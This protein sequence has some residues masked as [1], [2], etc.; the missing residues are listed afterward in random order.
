VAL[1]SPAGSGGIAVSLASSYP[2]GVNV[3]ASVTIAP[4]SLQ[5]TVAFTAGTVALNTSFTITASYLGVNK[6][7]G[8]TL[9][10]V[11]AAVAQVN[12][13]ALDT[14]TQ[15][16]WKGKYGTE[17]YSLMGDATQN[18]TYVVPSNNGRQYTWATSTS[19]V[20]ALQKAIGTDRIAAAWYGQ[21]SFTIDL[22]FTDQMPHQVAIYCLDWDSFGPRAQRIEILDANNNVLD[23]RSLSSFAGAST[24]FGMSPAAS[25]SELPR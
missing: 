9:I 21:P 7:A 3:P 2:A 5:A 4:G 22:N 14:T 1:S 11:P 16:N 13:V 12:F 6:G 19:D 10:P 18:P 23:T 8:G 24:W 15:G 25:R 20:R 17:G